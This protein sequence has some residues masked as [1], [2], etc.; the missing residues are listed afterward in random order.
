MAKASKAKQQSQAEI[1]YNRNR[2]RI[3]RQIRR[4]RAKG[5]DT[6]NFEIP[7]TVNQIKREKGKVTQ[8]DVDRI[9]NIK[10]IEKEIAKS[11]RY[12][13]PDTGEIF[14]GKTAQQAH[15]E[16]EKYAGQDNTITVDY[17]QL[18]YDA[19]SDLIPNE[20][21][22]DGKKKDFSQLKH[23]LHIEIN[24]I[25]ANYKGN[26][27]Y[28]RSHYEDFIYALEVIGAESSGTAVNTGYQRALAI[29]RGAP[30]T[31]YEAKETEYDNEYEEE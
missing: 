18:M 20:R 3:G 27:N 2:E 15:E 26:E 16:T 23:A 4:L 17:I 28:I 31:I 9:S 25:D 14:E 11:I 24:N 7:K 10:S 5:Y 1:E 19:V 29:L 21:Y 6:S 13:E 22:V 12:V 8:A 30:M